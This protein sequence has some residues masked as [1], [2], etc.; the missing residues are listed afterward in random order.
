MSFLTELRRRN[1]IRMN[2]DNS[3]DSAAS[4]GSRDR[5]RWFAL[6]VL[7]LG[8]L[9]IVLDITIVNVALPTIRENLGFSMRRTIR[10]SRATIRP[11]AG[12]GV[13]STTRKSICPIRRRNW[14]RFRAT[15][16]AAIESG[17][18]LTE[19]EA[20]VH[21]CETC[22]PTRFSLASMEP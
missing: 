10:S 6:A 3:Q 11:R 2:A 4:H 20:G 12:A 18:A 16:E 8:V 22:T 14:D 13:M 17:K 7:C 15:C 5:R 19:Q 21:V 9:M 1:V